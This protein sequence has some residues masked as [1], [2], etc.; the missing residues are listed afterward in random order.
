MGRP[1]SENQKAVAAR[2]RKNEAADAK[3]AALAKAKEDA[4]WVDNDKSVNAKLNR[5]A[6]K[7]IWTLLNVSFHCNRVSS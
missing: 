3:K 1:K 2:E 6:D 5:A 4:A 7:V